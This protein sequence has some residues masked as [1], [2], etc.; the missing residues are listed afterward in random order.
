M[1]PS[2]LLNHNFSVFKA[3]FADYGNESGFSESERASALGKLGMAVGIA[4]MLGPIAGSKLFASYADSNAAAIFMTI[5]SCGLLFL[6]PAPNSSNLTKES[7]DKSTDSD[8]NKQFTWIENGIDTIKEYFITFV[9]VPVMQSSGAKLLVS[10]RFG[11]GLAFNLFITVWTV[12]LKSRFNFGPTDHAYFMGWIGLWYS[13]SQG[14]I[15]R[16][17]IRMVGENPTNL[18]QI[19]VLF[20]SL[21]RVAVMVTSSLYMVYALMAAVLIALGV[22]NT[23]MNAAC[24]HLAGKDQMGGL[25]GVMDAAE[26]IAGLV[27]PALGGVLYRAHPH[28]PLVTVVLIYWAIFAAISRYYYAHVVQFSL[29]NDKDKRS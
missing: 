18:L 25:Y 23:A 11:M 10:M 28:F 13:L 17:S 20:L 29:V 24:A 19:C 9:H 16:A 7:I 15:A 5:I 22:M 12:S 14:F 1:V 27:G 4:F 26:S 2:T 8:L 6:L 3:L 21:G